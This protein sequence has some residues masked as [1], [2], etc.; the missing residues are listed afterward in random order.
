MHL[1]SL[2]SGDGPARQPANARA[3]RVASSEIVGEFTLGLMA[4]AA[5]PG[6]ARQI[7]LN[8]ETLRR[9]AAGG[10]ERGA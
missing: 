7:G 3:A 6:E 10:F 2:P 5:L 8:N 4:E 9:S 1:R